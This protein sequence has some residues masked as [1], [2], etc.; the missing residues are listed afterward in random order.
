MFSRACQ[1]LHVCLFVCFGTSPLVTITYLSRLASVA[2][3][4]ALDTSCML[5]HACEQLLVFALL[6]PI[7]RFLIGSVRY[8]RLLANSWI[9]TENRGIFG[10]FS[11]KPNSNIHRNFI[12]SVTC[13]LSLCLCLST[14]CCMVVYLARFSIVK[15][16]FQSLPMELNTKSHQRPLTG[17]VCIKLK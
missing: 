9:A 3:Y 8:L 13:V 17:R 15:D 6:T 10:A 11:F 2:L 1:R 4:P 14:Q 16:L 5:Y 7:T 12:I